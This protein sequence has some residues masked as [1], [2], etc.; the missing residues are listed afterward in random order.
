MIDGHPIGFPCPRCSFR[1]HATIKQIRLRD[2][3]I[4]RGCKA[5]IRLEDHRNSVR[6]AERQVRQS[7]EQLLEAMEALNTTITINL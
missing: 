1:N 6:I 7:L 4:C 3:L 5:N 2:V